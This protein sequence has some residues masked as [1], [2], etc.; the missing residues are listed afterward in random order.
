MKKYILYILL[1]PPL[2]FFLSA[3]EETK[4]VSEGNFNF[5][6]EFPLEAPVENSLLTTK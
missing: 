2:L 1:V 4:T 3:C 5:N 6:C